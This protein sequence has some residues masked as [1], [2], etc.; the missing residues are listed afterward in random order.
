MNTLDLA[1]SSPPHVGR[2]APSPSGPLHFGSLVA[3]AGS[4]LEARRHGGR[5]LLRIEDVN[6]PRIVPGAAEGI[7]ATLA[8]F[9]FEWDGEVVWQSRRNDA[10]RTALEQ[11]KA[12]G[13]AFPV[14]ARG[15]RWRIRRS[16]ATVRGATPAPAATACR[17]G[18]RHAHGGCGP[19]A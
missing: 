4:Y 2:F 8:R 15:A 9:G 14:P 1:S 11:L 5:W 12:A 7:I 17:P 3:A 19:K 6:T 10:Y 16:P 13:H 18:A